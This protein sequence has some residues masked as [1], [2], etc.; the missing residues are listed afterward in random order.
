MTFDVLR[1][2]ISIKQARL[3]P[4]FAR[5]MTRR[6]KAA[7][8][9]KT[10]ELER[11][12]S[13]RPTTGYSP[14]ISPTITLVAEAKAPQARFTEEGTRPHEIRGNPILAFYWEKVGRFVYFRKVNHPGN[15]AKPWFRPTIDDAG[16]LFRQIWNR[17]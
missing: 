7:A 8:P 9:K 6:L 5:E 12:I 1:R 3:A 11:S 4:V 10:G 16:A 15:K 13:V 2:E 14:R 17:T